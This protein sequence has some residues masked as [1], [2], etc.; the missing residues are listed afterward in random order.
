MEQRK[1]VSW[2]YLYVY[3]QDLNYQYIYG[4]FMTKNRQMIAFVVLFAVMT[5]G[6]S[7]FVGN[8]L[9]IQAQDDG[10]IKQIVY[11]HPYELSGE[12]SQ[13]T[14]ASYVTNIWLQATG[15]GL[16]KRSTA[17]ENALVADLG[18]LNDRGD[19][20]TST[21]QVVLEDGIKHPSGN[22][23]TAEDVVFS[24]MVSVDPAIVTNGGAIVSQKY[25]GDNNA[26]NNADT[27]D[28]NGETV[29]GIPDFTDHVKV[30]NGSTTTINF[31][32]REP[33]AFADSLIAGVSI[34]EKA[35]YQEGYAA[36]TEDFNSATGKDA[37]GAGPYKVESISLT[38]NLVVLEP[39]EHSHKPNG[40][41]ERIV[42][43]YYSTAEAALAAFASGDVQIIDSQFA[44]KE[45][46]ILETGAE[47][48]IVTDPATQQIIYNHHHPQ[49]GTGEMTP[50]GMASGATDDAKVRA[51]TSIR[52]AISHII[53]RD[54][55]V[56]TI[57][58]GLGSQGVTLFTPASLGFDEDLEYRAYDPVKAR[59]LMEAAGYDYNTLT[60]VD[61]TAD[62]ADL[63][64]S[65]S[66]FDTHVYSPNTNPNRNQWATQITENFKKIGI[67]FT[68]ESVGWGV[69]APRTF[70]WAPTDATTSG[71]VPIP[72]QKDG[73]FDMYFVGYSWALDWDPSDRY[74]GTVYSP[75]S[76]NAGNVDN[77]TLDGLVDMYQAEPDTSKRNVIAKTLQAAML[78]F[79][80]E[81]VIVYPSSVWGFD[82]EL[83]GQ[84]PL[85][86]S[87]TAQEWD[88]LRYTG[89]LV[90]AGA[91][92][93]G[94]GDNGTTT[95]GTT[96]TTGSDTT[97]DTPFYLDVAVAVFSL[98]G[99]LG[100]AALLVRRRSLR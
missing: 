70:Q 21:F 29:K 89:P 63:E 45:A 13:W 68:H 32:F 71:M 54:S 8:G 35:V 80:A 78:Q 3:V 43:R 18:T 77:A 41:I 39:N 60:A 47:P 40:D 15:A 26:S 25:F 92:P 65:T 84:S 12:Y 90:D 58:E 19:E 83:S 66:F 48:S 100:L 1:N 61:A 95:T 30:A 55:V 57:L 27:T 22:P 97:S 5:I 56:T 59:E 16:L 9:F 64:Y 10:K 36:G 69:L 98:I 4:E 74:D 17:A 42:L 93:A 34:I 52:Q 96:G 51:A 33:Y 2:T 53:N 31:D 88:L 11:A 72:L 14:A 24:F 50:N 81:S 28:E 38:N 94:P 20:N 75:A 67:G 6:M 73:G 7:S 44:Q 91:D 85:L 87:V 99:L 82:M 86:F 46:K 79:E 49:Y 37:N 76:N 62:P 23:I